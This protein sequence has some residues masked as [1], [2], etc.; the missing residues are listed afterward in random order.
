MATTRQV[1]SILRGLRQQG[2]T[3]RGIADFT[4]LSPSFV[5]DLLAGR[6]DIDPERAT[7]VVERFTRP[8]YQRALEALDYMRDRRS[9]RAAAERAGASPATIRKFAGRALRKA[10]TG[11]WR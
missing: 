10:P 2:L 6:R 1:R 8:G 5:S 3:Q 7:D 4:G 9:L 11:E